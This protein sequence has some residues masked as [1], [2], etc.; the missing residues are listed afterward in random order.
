MPRKI[1]ADAD[2][3]KMIAALRAKGLS[4][5]EIGELFGV[6]RQAVHRVLRSDASHRRIRCRVCDCGVN[7]AGAMPRD[8][9]EVFCLACLAKSPDATFGEHLQAYRLAAGLRIVALSKLTR[10][11]S[12]L[13]SAYEQGRCASAP[14]SIQRRLFRALGVRLVMEP[15]LSVPTPRGARQKRK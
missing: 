1:I 3:R 14:W 6:S 2:S 12:S 7:S 15:T 5:Y 9:R 8:D 13:L 10:I 4:D 11:N